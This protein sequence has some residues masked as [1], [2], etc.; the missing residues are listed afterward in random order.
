MK[1]MNMHFPD[2]IPCRADGTGAAESEKEE[3]DYE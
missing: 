1:P 2:G 3:Y